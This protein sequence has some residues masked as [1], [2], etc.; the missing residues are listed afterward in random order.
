MNM[1][2]KS[3]ILFVVAF[4]CK[5]LSPSFN[6]IRFFPFPFVKH[7]LTCFF[8][9]GSIFFSN[10]YLQFKRVI[11][12]AFI[13]LKWW[14]IYFFISLVNLIGKIWF[15]YFFGSEVDMRA[16]KCKCL[17]LKF[18]LN[19]EFTKDNAN[20]IRIQKRKNSSLVGFFIN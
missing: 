20:V 9:Q 8:Y 13:I 16:C 18:E 10:S 3:P 2:K 11:E 5:F 17:Y 1:K 7:P 15:C 6:S 12:D 19:I 14:L 4:V